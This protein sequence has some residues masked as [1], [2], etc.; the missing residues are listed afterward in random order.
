M[1]TRKVGRVLSVLLAIVMVVGLMIPA[2]SVLAQNGVETLD[3]SSFPGATWQEA[4]DFAELKAALDKI[5]EDALTYKFLVRSESGMIKT[6][7]PTTTVSPV[8]TE[9]VA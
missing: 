2:S 3:E 6:S 9:V 4:K 5:S 7:K 8:D 1:K